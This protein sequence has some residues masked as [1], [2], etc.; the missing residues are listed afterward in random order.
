MGRVPIGNLELAGANGVKLRD[1]PAMTT[2]IPA[3]EQIR[4]GRL[5]SFALAFALGVLAVVVGAGFFR[6]T[7]FL[8]IP[9]EIALGI[10]FLASLVWSLAHL[11]GK[12]KTKIALAFAPL[13]TN[14]ITICAVV[15][16]P[17]TAITIDLDFR[18]HLNARMAVVNGV[19][20]GKYNSQVESTGGRGDFIV[21]PSGLS[22]LSSGGEVVRFRR[23]QD[24]L[25]LFF[26]F[27]GILDSF[28]GFVY[29]A[30]DVPPKVGDFGGEF[31][32]IDRLQ[33]NWFWVSSR[34]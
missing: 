29:S 10:F 18:T 28:S 22:H 20:S 1:A 31:F 15:F 6:W 2:T 24:V 13:L 33:K 21:L 4:K 9:L 17:F 3:Q 23:Q 16:I 8:E 19:L 30:D 27:R 26:D 7:P 25:I 12:R 32:K 34:N 5:A 11:V 14:L